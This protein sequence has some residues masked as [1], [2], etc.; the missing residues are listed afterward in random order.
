MRPRND[1]E[2][3]GTP[4]GFVVGPHTFARGL[5]AMMRPGVAVTRGDALSQPLR[6]TEAE[7]R[8]PDDSETPAG[9]NRNQVVAVPSEGGKHAAT[10]R[11][12]R[13]PF[14]PPVTLPI[15]ETRG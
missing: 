14:T 3:E 10:Y 1:F 4:L 5:A 9:L 15:V 12:Q 7:S 2:P 13:T 6:R 8:R 11:P